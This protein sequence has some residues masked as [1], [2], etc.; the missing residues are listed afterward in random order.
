MRVIIRANL[1]RYD[2]AHPKEEQW[3]I[4]MVLPGERRLSEL[5]PPE[6]GPSIDGRPPSE[7]V[8][9]ISERVG[10]HWISSSRERDRETIAWVRENAAAID[11]LWARAEADRILKKI[12][13]LEQ[14]LGRLGDYFIDDNPLRETEE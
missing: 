10:S 14:T 1:G 7:I 8:E 3:H 5:W 9:E 4:V 13:G 6:Q 12:D 2:L 11:D